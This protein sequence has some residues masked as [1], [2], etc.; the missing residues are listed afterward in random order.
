ME[1]ELT[2]IIA[3]TAGSGKSTMMLQIEKLLK[4][5]GYNV[6]LSFHGNPDYTGEN[7]FHFHNKEGENFDKKSKAIKE[8]TRIVLKEAQLASL[9]PQ[10]F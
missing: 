3:G 8:N 2:V 7:T 5:N 1:K 9:P 6:E 4:E 10:L